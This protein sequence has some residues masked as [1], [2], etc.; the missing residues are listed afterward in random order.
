VPAKPRTLKHLLAAL[1]LWLPVA[2]CVSSPP[3]PSVAPG[4][5]AVVA[6]H[7]V[8]QSNFDRFAQGKGHAAGALAG[9]LAGQGAAAGALVPLTTPAGIVA[10]PIIAPF[11]ILAGALV[12]GVYGAA[13]GVA[14]GVSAE[15]AEDLARVFERAIA[16]IDVNRQLADRLA[17][18]LLVG[19]YDAQA[20]AGQQ[21]A[22]AGAEP[23]YRA[24][25][26]EGFAAVL[27]LTA[28][29]V[30]FAALKGP[31]PR[32]LSVEMHLRVRV[33]SLI[34][35]GVDGVER[36]AYRS[37]PRTL[38][39]WTADEGAALSAAF[40]EGYA[41]LVQRVMDSFF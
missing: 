40:Q 13:E 33:I 10:Y 6:A 17:A 19:G 23:D 11:T 36:L 14:G 35:Q 38:T 37:Q 1:A 3:L 7:T 30:G 39:Q 8:P 25:R 29:R 15:Q 20:V 21:P 22:G 28:E 2:G 16:E 32:R 26:D 5:I 24:L 18:R 41:V 9:E 4:R 12:G 27:E 31:S 34:G